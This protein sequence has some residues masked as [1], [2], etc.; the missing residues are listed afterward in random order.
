MRLPGVFVGVRRRLLLRLTAT[1][2]AQALLATAAALLV[3]FTF[4]H[5]IQPGSALDGAM[6]AAVGAG[7]LVAAAATA[8]LRWRERVDAEQLGQ[9]YARE[10]RLLLFDHL[11]RLPGRVLQRRRK[12]GV[13]LRFIGDLSALRQWLSFGLAKLTVAA[14]ATLGVLSALTLLAWKF[15]LLVAL[16]LIVTG[17]LSVRSGVSLRQAVKRARRQRARLANNIGEKASAMGV[18]QAFGQGRRERRRMERLS[19]ALYDA[20]IDRAD[21]LGRLRG[22]TEMTTAVAS[23][24]VLLLG[25]MEVAAGHTTPGT[26]VAAVA[27]VGMLV[28]SLRNLGRVHEYWHGAQVSRHNLERFLRAPGRL[29][30]V[31]RA[32]RL[33]LDEGRIELRK[34]S[35]DDSLRSVSVRVEG[36][37]R[38]AIIGANGAGKSTLLSLIARLTDADRGQV[39]LDGQDV[40]RCNLVSIRRNVGI[41]SPDLPLLRGSVEKNISYRL[42]RADAEQRKA[43]ADWCDLPRL[44]AEM[45]GGKSARVAEGGGNLS[46]GQRA[47]IALAR[48]LLGAPRILLL[49]EVDAN[50]DPDARQLVERILDSYPGTV[51]LVTHGAGLLS[52]VDRIWRLSGGQVTESDPPLAGVRKSDEVERPLTLAS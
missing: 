13:M 30:Q 21:R 9:D 33:Q 42:P 14:V 15:A 41:M 2:A 34:V 45:P 40:T 35:V 5:L 29:R 28:P 46:Q 38:I 32:S 23:A 31:A 52:K 39:L 49:D 4:D 17:G 27:L 3:R 11:L 7:L 50:L 24:G 44:F 36:G 25:A 18:V 26:L 48:A 10:L 22:L 43:V 8:W 51:L 47:R 19:R 37:Q 6:L 12:G 16:V 20:M 1:G